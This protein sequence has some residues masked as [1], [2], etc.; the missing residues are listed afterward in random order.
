MSLTYGAYQLFHI[1]EAQT[2]LR[3]L[4]YAIIMVV[5]YIGSYM[6]QQR[7]VFFNKKNAK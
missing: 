7:W 5:L 2:F 1:R 3:S 4:I 6:I